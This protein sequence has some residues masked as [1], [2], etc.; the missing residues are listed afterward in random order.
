MILNKTVYLILKAF[1]KRFFS[2]L[3]QLPPGDVELLSL[4]E[5][6]K[7][8]VLEVSFL[9]LGMMYYFFSFGQNKTL[10]TTSQ[11]QVW[12]TNEHLCL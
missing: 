5:K 9:F 1:K 12:H 7:F 11:T 6:K 8:L 2:L 10:P 3:P 4:E